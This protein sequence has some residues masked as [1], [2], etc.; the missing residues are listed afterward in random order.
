MSGRSKRLR[1]IAGTVLEYCLP[2]M[3][4]LNGNLGLRARRLMAWARVERISRRG[5]EAALPSA[6]SNLWQD[7]VSTQYYDLY[8]D[9]FEMWFRGTHRAFF[10]D[11]QALTR[12]QDFKHLV[13]V[14]CGDGKVLQHCV[15]HMPQIG[16]YCGI[17]INRDIIRRNR[18]VYAKYPEL[19][20][21]SG[22]A[23]VWFQD[24]ME[25]GLLMLSYGGV[26]EYFSEADLITLYDLLASQ[27]GT[28]IA[29]VEPVDPA[30]DMDKTL[31]SYPHGFE[32]SFSHNHRY[33]LEKAGFDVTLNRKSISG[34]IHWTEILALR[35]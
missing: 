7:G 29:L 24:H 22:D 17:D 3:G 14:G 16:R 2:W 30:H 19:N 10:Q 25:P 34:P 6:F 32:H 4:R 33:L 31:R 12:S 9:R 23:R 35:A 1:V 5:D 20:F 13:E 27:P 21:T 11:L 8:S 26:F 18:N 28:G 15:L